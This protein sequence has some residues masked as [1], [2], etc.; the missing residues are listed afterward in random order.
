MAAKNDLQGV[1][2]AASFL[3]DTPAW[4]L[5]VGTVVVIIGYGDIKYMILY[6]RSL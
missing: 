6:V 2:S 5:G 3:A 4:L 1:M